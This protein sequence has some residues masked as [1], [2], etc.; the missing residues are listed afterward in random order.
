MSNVIKRVFD[1]TL[2]F[3]GL[4]L[5]LPLFL[6]SAAAI[7]LEDGG[8][9]F[10]LQERCGKDG[11]LFKIIK[12]RTMQSKG[13]KDNLVVFIENDPRVTRIGRIL[14]ITAMDELPTLINILKGDV[15]FVG[16]RALPFKIGEDEKMLYDNISQVPGYETRSK[17]KP[18]LTGIAQI[19]APKDIARRNKFRYDNL[20]VH[21]RNLCL[22]IKL[23]LLSFWITFKGKWETKERKL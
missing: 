20:Y 17:V 1:F 11:K 19:Y 6:I 10:F 16:P 15:S 14:R 18:G 2:A 22:D 4:I 5:S 7:Y 23:I 12:L 9:I 3:L 8:P 13:E 21:N